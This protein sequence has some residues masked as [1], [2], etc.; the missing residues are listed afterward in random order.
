MNEKIKMAY[1][2]GCLDGDGSFSLIKNV[3]SG[4]IAPLYYPMV[5][6]ANINKVL[7]DLLYENFG[8]HTNT[9]ELYVGT[10]GGI[11]KKCH[12]WKL[13]KSTKCLPFLEKL[14]PYLVIKKE[15]AQFLRD[16]IEE[17]PFV[18]G[19][20][21]LDSETL[22]MRESSYIKMM[23]FNQNP[24][25]NGMLLSKGKR[26][27]C[28]D[29]EFWSYVA[30]LMDT[31]G[32]FSVKK[33]IR[34]TGGSKNPVH[35]PTILLTMTD[36]RAIYHLMNNFDGGN[37]CVVRARTATQGFCYRFS[38]TS[39]KIAIK[40]LKKVIPFLFI[41]K[42]TAQVLLEFSESFLKM[43]GKKGLSQEE[44]MVREHYYCKVKALNGVVK[45]SLMDLKPLPDNAGGNKAEGE[46]HRER[47][48]REDRESGCGA[49]NS[50]ET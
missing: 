44:L 38:I 4:H 3:S 43:N 14:I 32:S 26:A 7:I 50:M 17:N 19:S 30:G 37:L 18:R 36:C 23:G 49:L 47:S 20:N 28:E 40:F 22:Y 33:E 35:T 9:R 39:R 48:K 2:A 6:L 1:V 15:R 42:N 29:D 13:E 10:D 34:T 8:G 46:S 41:K 24:C 11:R 27:D 25:V 45:S 12:G 5:Q 16:F 21:R 31:D